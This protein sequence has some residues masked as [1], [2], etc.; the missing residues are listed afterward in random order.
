MMRVMLRGFVCCVLLVL[1]WE[2]EAESPNCMQD[3]KERLA[4]EQQVVE[5]LRA[6][7]QGPQ[8]IAHLKKQLADRPERL[9]LARLLAATYHAEGNVFWAQRTLQ[10][11][12]EQNPEDCASRSWLAWIHLQQGD[13]DLAEEVL[14]PAGC[15]KTE[16]EKGRWSLLRV[17]IGRAQKDEAA[18]ARFFL[19]LS[20]ASV[21]FS[22]DAVAMARLRRE[23]DPGWIHPLHLRAEFSM[24]ATS[25][26]SAGLPTTQS[27]TESASPMMR[28]DLFGRFVWPASSWL[29]PAMEV[30]LKGHY[31]D[32]F[33]YGDSEDVRLGNYLDMSFRPGLIIGSGAWRGFVGY[34]NDVFVMNQGDDYAAAPLVFYEGHR[35]DFELET[36]GNLTLFAG[37]G[38]R[39]FRQ[40][41]RSRWEVD[42]GLGWSVAIGARL[43]LLLAMSLR[44]YEANQDEYSQVGGTVLAVGH[45]R[46]PLGARLRVGLTLG[47]DYY[48]DSPPGEGGRD[49]LIKPSLQ[50]WSPAWHGFWLGA[51]YEYTWRDSTA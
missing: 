44:S 10:A 22:E 32:D 38:R 7:G 27:G 18:T 39:I 8:A 1:A 15:P 13:L 24:G 29:K 12:I 35:A 34:R 47:L 4:C 45:W 37:A 40:M 42:G 25:N 14:A 43:Q 49:L 48:P 33:S 16:A 21:L 36:P 41:S 3:C 2:A 23:M 11:L 17:M 30:G 26:A 28:L 6:Q 46:L 9:D 19:K 50:L 20:G 51:V 31:L 5:C